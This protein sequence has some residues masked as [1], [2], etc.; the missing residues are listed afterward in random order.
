MISPPGE[1]GRADIYCGKQWRRVQHITEEFWNR[2]HKEFLVTL[3]QCQK[4]SK[5]RNFQTGDIVLLKN[6]LHHENH[7]PMARVVEIFAEK[8]GDVQNVKLKLGSQLTCGS[9]LLEQPMLKIVLIMES[10]ETK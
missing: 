7:W 3:Q 5:N 10:N 2:W 9:A 8:H 1:F 6:D 4:W